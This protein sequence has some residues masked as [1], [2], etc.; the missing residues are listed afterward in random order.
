M[1]MLIVIVVIRSRRRSTAVQLGGNGVGNVLDLLEFLLEVISGSRLTLRVDPIGG[2]LDGVQE[3]L[4]VIV[5]QLAT[6][7]FRVTELG[8]EAVDVGRE[9]VESFDALLLGFI[10]GGE[11]LGLGNHTVD[12]LLSETSLLVGD[13]DRLGFT[14]ALVG[15]E[16]FMIPLASISNVTSIWGTP[17]GAGGMPVSSNLPRRLLSLVRERSP[18]KTWIKTV[19]WLS[20]AVEK[21]WLLRVGM[22]VL[23]GMSLVMTPPVVSIPRVR[24]LTSTRTTSPKLSSPVRIPP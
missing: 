22:T 21:I 18:S 24:G 10:L 19:G 2:L 6:E 7:T 12:L 13:G 14:S 1:N 17:R 4:L 15:A 11:L 8:L 16:T 5:V 23:R 20:A 9:G 3:R